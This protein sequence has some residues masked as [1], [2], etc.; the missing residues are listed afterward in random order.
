MYHLGE[1]VNVFCHGSL[2]ATQIDVA[3]PF[4]TPILYGTVDGGVGVIVQVPQNFY[5]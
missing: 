5:K 3:P 4:H 1:L 2:I